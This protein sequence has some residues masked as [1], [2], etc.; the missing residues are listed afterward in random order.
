MNEK[1]RERESR[2]NYG[3][4]NWENGISK[5]RCDVGDDEVN[6]SENCQKCE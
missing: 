5:M 4:A 1:K 2:M 6:I 3:T